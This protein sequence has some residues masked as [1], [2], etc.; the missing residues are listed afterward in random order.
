MPFLLN[1]DLN[2]GHGN[3][4]GPLYEK[5]DPA[6]QEIR[7]LTVQFGAVEDQPRCDIEVLPLQEDPDFCRSFLSLGCKRSQRYL[8]A[9]QRGQRN[10][11]S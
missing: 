7:L 10:N 9:R 6:R 5:L 4:S 8:R 11:Q 3:P 2:G 1:I